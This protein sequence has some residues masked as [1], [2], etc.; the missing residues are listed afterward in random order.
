VSRTRRGLTRAAAAIGVA[1]AL[2]AGYAAGGPAGLIDAAAV[3]GVGVL[4]V[5]RGTIPGEKPGPVRPKD[6]LKE[7][8]PAVRTADFPAYRTIASDLEWAQLSRRHYQHILHPRLAR[9]AV[10]L[11]RPE[12]VAADLAGARAAGDPNDPDGPGVDLATLNRIVA[13]LEDR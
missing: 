4:V 7:R 9:L 10:T 8:S 3:A 13:R 2:G 6:R 5:A 12:A 1:A 11:G